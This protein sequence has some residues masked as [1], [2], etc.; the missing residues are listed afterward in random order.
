MTA[1]YTTVGDLDVYR[2]VVGEGPPLVLLPGGLLTW[3]LN[4]GNIRDALAEEHTTI[5]IELQGHGRTADIDRAPSLAAMADDVTAVLADLGHERAAVY[6]FSLGAMVAL[7]L[8]LRTPSVVERLVF[9][10]A[11]YAPDGSVDLG[12]P[13]ADPPNP[14]MPTPEDFAAMEAAYRAV[15]PDPDGF[16]AFSE[17]L[18]PTVHEY[19]GWPA[20]DIRTLETPTLVLLG[21]TDFV[22]IEHAAGMA[23]LL[24]H[25]Q[26]AVVPDAT[27][28][29]MTR[30]PEQVLALIRPFLV[31]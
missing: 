13:E 25:G 24:P 15:A 17:K 9:G 12:D 18:Q 14:R 4:F 10:S 22:T 11:A 3:E 30:R 26:L 1:G 23:E 16:E 28:M 21:D 6:G 7:E 2:E 5:A 27:H 8:A 19:V 31:S 29:G 20:G